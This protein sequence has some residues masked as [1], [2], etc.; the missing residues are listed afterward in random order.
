MTDQQGLWRCM[1][2][3]QYLATRSPGDS[4]MSVAFHGLELAYREL[5]GHLPIP[6]Y[7]A[8]DN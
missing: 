8:E 1:R 6:G 2:D 3:A 4:R 5:Y 7:V